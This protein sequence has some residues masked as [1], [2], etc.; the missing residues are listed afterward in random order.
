MMFTFDLVLI[1]ENF[2]VVGVRELLRPFKITRPNF[3]ADSV[4][5]LPAHTIFRSRT[6]VGDQLVIERFEA[7]KAVDPILAH[8]PSP[9]V[10]G[11]AAALTGES[12]FSR[13]G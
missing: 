13:I 5:E 10:G 7:R 3:K 12:R 4:L 11:A 6:E 1:D 2:R 8:S 9:L